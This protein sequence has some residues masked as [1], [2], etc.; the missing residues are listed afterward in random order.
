MG[1]QVSRESPAID[2]EVSRTG[3]T[4]VVMGVNPE[5][6]ILAAAWYDEAGQVVDVDYV[7]WTMEKWHSKLSL[8]EWSFKEK[9]G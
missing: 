4:G 5:R 1:W 6:V 3:F 8:P 7:T 9:H 2:D